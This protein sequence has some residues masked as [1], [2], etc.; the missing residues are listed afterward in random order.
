MCS[1]AARGGA[2]DT[3]EVWAFSN[4]ASV[5]LFVNGASAGVATPLKGNLSHF[6]WPAVTYVAGELKAVAYDAAHRTIA[7]QT[8]A[9]TGA[10]AALR[11]S[12]KDGVGN[13]TA[14]GHAGGLVAGCDDVALVMVEVVDAAGRRVPTASDV[15]SLEVV[16]AG[17]APLA[18]LGGGNGDPS[19]LTSDKSAVRPAFHGLLLGVYGSTSQAGR[20]TVLAT[21]PGLASA[22]IQIEVREPAFEKVW[23]CD[24]APK[25]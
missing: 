9:T 4:A 19:E 16:P 5:E 8:V 20:A 1:P 25:L 7:T 18:F 23:W 6:E 11:V 2:P 22:S 17:G 13:A 24:R 21:A 3:V 12:I 15:V 14:D 10:A